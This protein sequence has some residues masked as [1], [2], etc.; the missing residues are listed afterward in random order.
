MESLMVSAVPTIAT[1]GLI[2]SIFHSMSPLNIKISKDI[3]KETTPL[4]IIAR[5]AFGTM[6]NIYGNH[7]EAVSK[8]VSAE[9]IYEKIKQL[10]CVLDHLDDPLLAQNRTYLQNALIWNIQERSLIQFAKFHGNLDYAERREKELPIYQSLTMIRSTFHE[11]LE[12]LANF[13]IFCRS[14]SVYVLS[15]P[16]QISDIGRVLTQ[17]VTNPQIIHMLYDKDSNKNTRFRLITHIHKAGAN[18]DY[19]DG[20]GLTLLHKVDHP[21]IA[22]LLLYCGANPN[23]QDKW[24]DTP[25]HVALSKEQTDKE[26][27]FIVKVLCVAKA[28]LEV[29]NTVQQTPIFRVQRVDDLE[30][31]LQSRAEI[32]VQDDHG[33]SLLHV[34]I[35]W[36][37]FE[38]VMAL[39][40]ARKVNY[41]KNSEGQDPLG[42]ALQVFREKTAPMVLLIESTFKSHIEKL[43]KEKKAKEQESQLKEKAMYMAVKPLPTITEV[44]LE[45]VHSASP[46][47]NNDDSEG[48]GEYNEWF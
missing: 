31:L 29:R 6:D 40:S 35:R 4:Q 11:K 26:Q 24:G 9:Y 19:Q 33:N 25:L 21:D 8:M 3:S 1:G 46:S 7:F 17:F 37:S 20:E 16:M 38:V 14:S 30:I 13:R 43:A 22:Q 12:M 23:I 18:L 34:L 36:S 32:N 2:S 5:L 28:N 15:I 41:I 39:L 42:C 27:T 45:Y 48:Y 44:D 47:G 10:D